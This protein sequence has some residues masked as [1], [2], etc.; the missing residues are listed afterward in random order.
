[1]DVRW[2]LRRSGARLSRSA[3]AKLLVLASTYPRWAGDPEPGFVHQLARRLLD[4]FEVTVLTPH[5]PGA[6]LAEDLDGVQVRRY[7]YAPE[8]LET[9]VHDG[10]IITNLRGQPWKWLLVP[11]FLC[12]MAWSAW[13][14]LRRD[15]PDVIH[16]HWLLPQGLIVA[17]LGVLFNRMPPFVVT[18]HGADLFAL[19]ATPLQALKRFV[20]GRAAALTVVSNAMRDELM[21]IGVDPAKVRVE[22]MGVDMEG[23]FSVDP[24][25]TRRRDEILFVG[26]LVEKKGLRHLIDAM[27]AILRSYP[28]AQLTIAGFG[29]E[30]HARREQARHLGLSGRVT[31]L[32]AVAQSDLPALYRRAAVL[33]APFVRAPGGDQEGLGLVLVEAAACGCP[34]VAGD[35]PAIRDVLCD[36]SVGMRV[37]PGDVAALADAVCAVLAIPVTDAAIAA[38]LRAVQHF[39]WQP[40]ADAY[41]ALLRAQ[42][43][44]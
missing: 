35:V 12:A 43:R 34:I 10:G 33:V 25:V 3:R 17:G 4:A 1:M 9:L 44:S 28:Q 40:R 13:R 8:A 11:A 2:L 30:I 42:V 31:F 15:R 38:R 29:P 16:A 6:A 41:A 14:T 5:A 39:D 22:P 26:R 32:G 24:A 19:R 21:R 27:P 37:A 20:A 7:R 18:S 23:R 36:D